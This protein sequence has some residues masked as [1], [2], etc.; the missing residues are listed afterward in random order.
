MPSRPKLNQTNSSPKN[1][2][3]STRGRRRVLFQI[4]AEPGRE[5]AVAGNF[6][7]WSPDSHRL[8]ETGIPGH[9]QRFVYLQ[10]GAYQYKFVIDGDW[11]ADPNCPA[12]TTNEFGTLNSVIKVQR[13]AGK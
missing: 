7:A 8:K 3:P 5:V 13:A 11:S 6:N 4:D 1:T 2:N 12:F 10:P 9:Y